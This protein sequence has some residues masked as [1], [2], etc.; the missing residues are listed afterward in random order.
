VLLEI[1]VVGDDVLFVC[2][3]ARATDPALNDNSKARKITVKGMQM[4]MLLFKS[5]A[6]MPNY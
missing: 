1:S 6:F 4:L 2:V 3:W 5:T